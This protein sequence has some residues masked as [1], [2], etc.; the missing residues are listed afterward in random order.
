[1]T[2]ADLMRSIM[3][4]LSQAGHM[5]F[6]ANVGLLYTRDGRP[7]RTGLPVGFSDLFGFSADLT[8]FF[9][10]VKTSSGR[11]S[12]EQAAFLDAMR[13]RGAIAEVVRSPQ[14]A[15]GFLSPRVL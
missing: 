8:P 14:A 11:V 7:V 5:V 13:R 3:L 10:E 2:E 9:F 4:A 1:M 12:P 6:R 15:L